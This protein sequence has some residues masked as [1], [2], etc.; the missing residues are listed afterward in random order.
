M[1]PPELI[2]DA[3]AVEPGGT[4]SGRVRWTGQASKLVVELRWETRGKGDRD[5]ETVMTTTIPVSG[6]EGRFSLTAPLAPFSFS[7]TLVSVLYFVT[8][9]VAG[10]KAETEI[11]I[12]PG[13]AEVVLARP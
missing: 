7:G 12:A 11:V 10:G 3:A 9:K 13:G 5:R 1:E 4:I 8:A 2:L 6:T